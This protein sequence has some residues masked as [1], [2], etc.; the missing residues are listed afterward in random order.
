MATELRTRQI[1]DSAIT[2][3]KVA[4]DAAIATS[5]LGEGADFLKRAGTVALTGNLPAG[6]NK[7]TGLGAPTAGSNDAARIIDIENAIANLNSIFKT[8]P[9]ARAATTANINLSSP[10]ATHDTIALNINEILFVRVQTDNTQNGLYTFNGAAVPLTRILQMDSWAEIPGAFFAVEEGATFS[11]TLWLCTANQGGTL[12]ITPVPFQQI[13]STA[14]LAQSNFPAPEVPSGAINGSN[15]T[16]TL[17][18]TP[19]ANSQDLYLNGQLLF[20]GAGEDYTITG[21]TITLA[22]APLAGE[23]LVCRYRI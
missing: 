17:S 13:P 5:K 23:R 20:V 9:N 22:V 15:V 7:I 18:A 10:G 2:N 1:A 6:N 4:A 12:G 16:F 19:F 14:G 8:K 3:A 21:S 11:D